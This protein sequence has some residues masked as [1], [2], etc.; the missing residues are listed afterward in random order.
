MS[1][2]LNI[3][4]AVMKGFIALFSPNFRL[5]EIENGLMGIPSIHRHRYIP[6]KKIQVHVLQTFYRK[7]LLILCNAILRASLP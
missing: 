4:F 5:L 7:H 2:H 3:K 1:I 6:M